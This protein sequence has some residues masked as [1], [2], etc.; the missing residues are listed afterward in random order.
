[1][2][3]RSFDTRNDF[4]QPVFGKEI[5]PEFQIQPKESDLIQLKAI[6]H[7]FLQ[8]YKEKCKK[9]SGIVAEKKTVETARKYKH[10][11]EKSKGDQ[12]EDSKEHQAYV[13]ASNLDK[14]RH[15]SDGHHSKRQNSLENISERKR[16]RT[17]HE[18]PLVVDTSLNKNSSPKRDKISNA[19][20]ESWLKIG[21]ETKL[22]L[23]NENV[24]L[25]DSWIKFSS[26]D[27]DGVLSNAED[28]IRMTSTPEKENRSTIAGEERDV[29]TGKEGGKQEKKK[30]HHQKKYKTEKG[31]IKQ[32]DKE[33]SSKE[34]THVTKSEKT[35]FVVVLLNCFL[36]MQNFSLILSVSISPLLFHNH[37]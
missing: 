34:M 13:Q 26:P 15:K 17:T 29:E 6:R 5:K 3:K 14:K 11:S 20:T 7:E 4:T 36:L 22:P 10:K 35:R 28:L 18:G 1:M 24:L 23:K 16:H 30:K 31:K 9:S 21:F 19:D 2:A 25:E 27:A 8:Q 32:T 33:V 12:V 37:F